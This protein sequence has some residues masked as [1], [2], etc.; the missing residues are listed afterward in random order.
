[1]SSRPTRRPTVPVRLLAGGNPQIPMGLGS[2]PVQAYLRAMP[3]WKRAVGRK[4]DALVTRIVP[5][6]TKA[7]KWN[8]PLYGMAGQGWF[9]SIHCFQNFVR[10]SFFNGTSLDPLPPGPSKVKGNRYYDIRDVKEI[11]IA[12]LTSWV[13]QASRLPG[14][15]KN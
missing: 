9:L 4:V 11:D 7:V 3:G 10:L 8:S 15:G 13:R 2:A 14:W 1:M 6:V 5:D 12:R